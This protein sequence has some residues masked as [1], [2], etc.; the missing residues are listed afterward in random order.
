[1]SDFI[2][3][4]SE[5]ASVR[6]HEVGGKAANLARLARAGLPTP[7]GFT[8]T[9]T[10]YRHQLRHLDVEDEV[11]AYE[12]A[13]FSTRLRLSVQVRL[14]LYQGSIAPAIVEPLIDAWRAQRAEAPLG[15]VRSSALVEDSEDASFAGQFESFLGLSDEAEFLTAIRACWAAL[16]TSRASRYMEPHGLSPARTAMAILIQPLIQA[17]AAGGA[18]SRTAEGEMLISATWGLGSA[19]AQGE[20]VPDRI[21]LDQ[22]GRVLSMDAGQKPQRDQC[23]H[24]LGFSPR[25]VP[26]RLACEA[27]ISVKQAEALGAMLIRAERICGGPVEIEWAL[28][29]TWPEASAGTPAACRARSR[30]RSDLASAPG[31]ARPPRG[32]RLGRGPQRSRALRVRARPR[33]AGRHSRHPGGRSRAWSGAVARGWSRHGARRLDLT[34]RFARART[35]HPDGFGRP[36]RHEQDSRRIAGRRRRRGGHRAVDELMPQ[37]SRFAALPRASG[38]FSP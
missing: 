22:G 19:L 23:A 4:L 13:D 11:R 8:L 31:P 25:A 36:R 15:A 10:A 14:A 1:M 28:D 3:K 12:A 21:A 34:P 30:A 2:I 35:R 27:S 33:R 17:H 9:A 18:L 37:C 6:A 29:E 16:W 32:D 20:V 38:E 24:G 7:G 5:P 26:T